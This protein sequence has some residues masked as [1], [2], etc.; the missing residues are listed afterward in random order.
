M[1]FQ[2]TYIVSGV[3][4][5]PTLPNQH[6]HNVSVTTFTSVTHCTAPF[7]TVRISYVNHTS[8]AVMVCRSVSTYAHTRV[9]ICVGVAACVY[10]HTQEL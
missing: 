6:M 5:E 1:H 4:R 10:T 8:G 9:Y 3:W 7:G 2:D